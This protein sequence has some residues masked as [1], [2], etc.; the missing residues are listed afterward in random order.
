MGNT[1]VI[2]ENM[3]IIATNKRRNAFVAGKNGYAHFKLF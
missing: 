2:E 3:K 1:F